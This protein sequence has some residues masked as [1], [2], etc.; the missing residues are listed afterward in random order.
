MANVALRRLR[1]GE[2]RPVLEVFDGMSDGSRLSRFH[3]PKPRLRED[4]LEQLVDVG[5][6]GRE[7]V[8]AVDAKSGR[9]IGIA[10]FVRDSLDPSS[11]EVAFDVIDEWQGRGVGRRLAREL[12]ALAFRQGVERFRADVVVGNEPALA[13]LRGLGPVVSARSEDGVFE[14]VVELRRALP[15]TFPTG[16]PDGSVRWVAPAA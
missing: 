14:L 5:C 7:A 4:D 16:R 2:R 9:S 1:R 6:C 10:R 15:W 3:A 11:A 8:A 13:L 12:R